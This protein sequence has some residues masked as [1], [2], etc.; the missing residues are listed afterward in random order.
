MPAEDGTG[1]VE[2]TID[3]KST[4]GS[5][6][7]SASNGPPPYI[8]TA[9][10][11]TFNTPSPGSPETAIGFALMDASTS[12]NI[13]QV[14]Y[15]GN[16]AWKP[17][18]CT[19]ASPGVFTCPGH[20]LSN[21]DKVVVSDR[22][23]GTLPTTGGSF[24]GLLTVA[25]VSGDTFDVGVNTTGTGNGMFRKVTTYPIVSG[26]DVTIAAGDLVLRLG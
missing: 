19:S 13:Q 15:L 3:R 2:A 10:D 20:G 11:L 22:I 5:D 1:Y 4:A 23:A 14:D 25:N 26:A 24:A 16:H 21:G 17:F 7:N 12:G 6:W 9:A 18:T 8:D